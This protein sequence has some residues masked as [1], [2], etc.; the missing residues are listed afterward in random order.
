[1][2]TETKEVEVAIDHPLEELFEI[3][4]GTTLMPH[5]ERTTDLIAAEEYDQKD[6][7][8]EDQFQEVYDAA[9][10]AFE[11]CA[12]EVEIVEGKYKARMMEVANQSLNTALAAVKEKSMSKQHKDKL[13]VAKGKLGGKTVNNNLVIADRNQLLKSFGIS[14]KED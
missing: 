10:A 13:A 14:K 11:D 3:E 7:E 1:M 6:T 12:S 4:S 2:T 5:T 8:I 9:F